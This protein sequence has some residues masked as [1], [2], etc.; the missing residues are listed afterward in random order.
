MQSADDVDLRRPAGVRRPRAG[1]DLLDRKLVPAFVPVRR[2]LG[3]RSIERAELAAQDAVVRVVDVEVDV[4]VR[5]PAMES[6]TDRVGQ[7]AE[8]ENVRRFVKAN[9][10]LQRKRLARLDASFCVLERIRRTR[11]H[12]ASRLVDE[13][14]IGG[15]ACDPSERVFRNPDDAT[16]RHRG[17]G[18]R[19]V[20]GRRSCL[21]AHAT[22][23]IHWR[24]SRS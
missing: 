14:I 18:R 6:L 5:P 22:P 3:V 20:A 4:V 10:L 8:S 2:L 24:P 23:R 13:G 1:R 21:P 12:I 17:C 7:L 11:D 15:R 19:A 16:G 9:A